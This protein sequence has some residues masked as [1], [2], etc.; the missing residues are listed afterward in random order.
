MRRSPA[1]ADETIIVKGNGTIFLAGP[2]LVRAATGEVVTAEELGG[3][4]VHTRISGVADHF[5]ESEPEAL[6]KVREIVSHLQQG[7]ASRPRSIPLPTQQ[8]EEPL[9][10]ADELY[11]IIPAD[12]RQAYDVR[13]AACIGVSG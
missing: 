9:Y 1:M 11:G 12:P 13:E 7:L 5:A 6:D 3:G 2:P 10:P 8:P 4:D